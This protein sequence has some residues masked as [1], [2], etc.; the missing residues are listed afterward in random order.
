MTDRQARP[1]NC[2][3]LERQEEELINGYKPKNVLKIA[4]YLVKLKYIPK[5]FKVMNAKQ[6]NHMQIFT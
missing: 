5:Q 6:I 1:Q 2:C 4:L 3:P